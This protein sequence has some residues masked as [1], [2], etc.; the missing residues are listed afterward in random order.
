MSSCPRSVSAVLV[1]FLEHW[2]SGFGAGLDQLDADSRRT[3]MRACGQACARSYTVSVFQEARAAS[4]DL[5]SLLA[6]LGERFRGA[7]Y[8]LLDERHVEVI[9]RECACD[10]VMQGWVNTPTLCEC[11][12]H[13]LEANFEAALGHPVSV[14]MESSIL[15][16]ATCCK[17]IVS[18]G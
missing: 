9:Y 17:F 6:R 2:F 7:K 12:S 18:I 16:G 5:P 14:H 8:R 10:L 3:L 11:S 1:P 13:N 15:A 4:H